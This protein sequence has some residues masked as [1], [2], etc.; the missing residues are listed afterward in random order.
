MDQQALFDQLSAH[1]ALPVLRSATPVTGGYLSRNW[2]LVA[3]D[4]G[5]FLQEYRFAEITPVAAAHASLFHFQRA[6]IP[7]IPPLP[8]RA[9]Q[10]IW[11]YAGR[12]YALFPFVTARQLRRGA[13]SVTAVQSVG[14]ML[15]QLHRAG[16][17]VT[18][19]HVQ[20]R[21]LKDNRPTFQKQ[22]QLIL[23]LIQRQ[24]AQSA[25]DQLAV[26]TLQRQLTLVEQT[27][28]DYA[29]LPLASDHLL[30]GDFHDGNL[31][32]DEEE[33]VQ[34]VFDWEKT[35][36]A[37]REIELIR[38]LLFICF[39]NPDNFCATFAP[40]NFSL[41]EAFLRAY[42]ARYPV[43]E[44]G[45]I[46]AVHARYWGSLCSLWVVE[47][48]YLH[49]NQRVDPFLEATLTEISYFADHLPAF[50]RWLQAVLVQ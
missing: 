28:I 38:A 50:V 18:L 42:Q 33:Q 19:P 2:H 7:T 26:R 10:T 1:Y 37:P 25:F 11:S 23:D 30:H 6:G 46:A 4:S 36:I 20:R 9:G 24:P 17:Q 15:A 8:T 40:V 49:Q 13:L 3:A 5:Y 22:A 27:A 44:K 35:E 41:G 14:A 32:F 48:H 43:A 39:S 31:F 29:T 45:L 16:H 12:F 21:R 47:E 34:A